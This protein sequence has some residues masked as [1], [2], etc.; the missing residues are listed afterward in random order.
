MNSFFKNRQVIIDILEKQNIITNEEL[1]NKV[2]RDKQAYSLVKRDLILKGIAEEWGL[3]GLTFRKPEF[4]KAIDY[5]VFVSYCHKNYLPFKGIIEPL[6][7]NILK[8]QTPWKKSTSVFFDR[9]VIYE[10]ETFQPKLV[11]GIDKAKLLLV[12]LTKEYL[13]SNYCY[14]EWETFLGLNVSNNSA[15]YNRIVLLKTFDWKNN[16]QPDTTRRWLKFLEN[17]EVNVIDLKDWGIE[18]STEI[19]LSFVNSFSNEIREILIKTLCGLYNEDK[20]NS[21]IPVNSLSFYKRKNE[22]AYLEKCIK[23]ES[24]GSI[25]AVVGKRGMGK[26]SLLIH[27][28]S[29]QS[30]IYAGGK[31]LL[32]YE[33]LPLKDQICKLFSLKNFYYSEAI[34]TDDKLSLLYKKITSE[35][36]NGNRT[37]LI[38]SNC[39][40]IHEVI[41]ELKRLNTPKG[42]DIFLTGEKKTADEFNEE[43][44]VHVKH[45]SKDEIKSILN[46]YNQ[47]WPNDCNLSETDI[48][49]IKNTY[50][51]KDFFD[52]LNLKQL[53]PITTVQSFQQAKAILKNKN[54]Y[55]KNVQRLLEN[56]GHFLSFSVLDNIYHILFGFPPNCI[57][58]KYID[59]ILINTS[60]FRYVKGSIFLVIDLLEQY[61]LVQRRNNYYLVELEKGYCDEIKLLNTNYD[62]IIIEYCVNKSI[63]LLSSYSL[64]QEWQ[65]E[66]LIET[67]K[68][69][70]HRKN[71][72]IVKLLLNT[73]QLNFGNSNFDLTME[74]LCEKALGFQLNENFTTYDLNTLKLHLIKTRSQFSDSNVNIIKVQSILNE[75]GNPN[76]NNGESIAFGY[77]ILAQLYANIG[78]N[79]QAEKYIEKG[80]SIAENILKNNQ[81]AYTF[82]TDLIR[83]KIQNP[84]LN[85]HQL[86]VLL[87]KMMEVKIEELSVIDQIAHLDLEGEIK[88]QSKNYI[89]ASRYYEE[90]IEL[91]ISTFG[92]NHYLLGRIYNNFSC[93]CREYFKDDKALELIENAINID[94]YS[95][96]ANS[97]TLGETYWN[98]STVLFDHKR[99][100]EAEHYIC[101]AYNI[102]SKLGQTLRSKI[103]ADNIR[104]YFPNSATKLGI[105]SN[106]LF[107][108]LFK[109]LFG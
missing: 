13:D 84:Q 83:I 89:L 24:N 26:K 25:I 23:S 97:F 60:S 107:G 10:N 74:E 47:F 19:D 48:L 51:V 17:S 31:F 7:E 92:K 79:Y 49:E 2:N 106:S 21:N 85:Y 73:I 76:L 53:N 78:N 102:Y 33:K 62:N 22:I 38:L 105:Q 64:E 109:S 9:K 46:D 14:W 96:P 71:S 91:C 90:A 61:G 32:E 70:I 58:L 103:I 100:K 94:I 34:N 37:A 104:Q 72:L 40:N 50:S 99:F 68:L 4:R 5:D 15:K 57:N 88:R 11:E 35:E 81:I 12:F 69:Y 63:K 55:L 82:Y 59:D 66:T 36:V 27:F 86:Q 30:E 18:N 56:N 42:L 108:S 65:L 16:A 29:R 41:E 3:E 77:R 54:G 1:L 95:Y 67:T 6:I 8:I 39:A 43:G 44:I 28:L 20:I 52:L 87:T 93:L 80:L 101:L 75:F 45:F 98:Y